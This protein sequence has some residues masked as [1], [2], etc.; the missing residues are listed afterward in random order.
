MSIRSR[1]VVTSMVLS[2]DDLPPTERLAYWRDLTTQLQVPVEWRTDQ[3]AAFRAEVH[4]TSLGALS[5]FTADCAPVEIR[6]TS[7]LTRQA[8]PELHVLVGSLRGR[9]RVLQEQREATLGP[10]DLTLITTSRPFRGWVEADGTPAKLAAL[11][12]PSTLLPLHPDALTRL[13][14]VRLSGRDGIG[15]LVSGL[16]PDLARHAATCRLA[17][18]TRLATAILE[19]LAALFVGEL[20]DGAPEAHETNR[21]A[22]LQAQAYI[23]QRLGDPALAPDAIAA[24]HHISTRYLHKLFQEQGMTVAGWIRDRRLERCRRDLV[25]PTLASSSIGAIA[26]R[27]GLGGGAHFSRVFRTAYG[28][29]PRGYRKLHRELSQRTEGVRGSVETVR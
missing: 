16:V 26:E 1:H 23:Q 24:A 17:A 9:V 3:E 8:D 14:A 10:A 4:A 18:A 13:T 27:W 11:A 21:R 25:D 19:L 29:S 7:A 12:F 6:R 15:A 5:V 28:V 2:A 22:L 20:E